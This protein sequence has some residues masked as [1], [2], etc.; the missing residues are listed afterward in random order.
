VE[1]GR[2][3]KVA[4]LKPQE[5][6]CMVAGV[7]AVAAKAPVRGALLIGLQRADAADIARQADV[8]KA[9]AAATLRKL[10]ELGMLYEDEEIGAEV[11]RDWDEWQVEPRADANSARRQALHRNV[12]LRTAIR[13]RDQGLCRYCAVEVQWND[14]RGLQG[15]TYDHIDPRGDN[16]AENLV[17]ACRACN[18]RKRDRSAEQ[19]GM[20]LLAP[21]T[22]DLG[23][24]TPEL[25]PDLG[26]STPEEEGEVVEVEHPP[27]PPQ[28]GEVVTFE[29][30]PVAPDR[31]ALARRLLDEFNGAASTDYGAFTAQGKPSESL[32]RIIG[33]LTRSAD[34]TFEDGAAAIR[35]RLA[36]PFW[37]GKA[38]PGVVF[39]PGVFDQAQQSAAATVSADE[40]RRRKLVGL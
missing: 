18:S 10:R 38:H 24:S 33:A 31:L 34:V 13:A 6:W 23:F 16:E 4:R 15:G 25:D 35:W 3:L 22:P 32:K 14:R 29:R 28:G 27:K 9:M 2:N 26:F 7:L 30:R 8:S 5:R 20:T 37:E 39:G 1:I 36:N 21:P 17:V 12:D 11:V 40:T 19:A